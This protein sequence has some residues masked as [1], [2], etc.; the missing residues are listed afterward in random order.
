MTAGNFINKKNLIGK[1]LILFLSLIVSVGAIFIIGYNVDSYFNAKKALR[2]QAEARLAR[3]R[4]AQEEALR[5]EQK[6]REQAK[7]EVRRVALLKDLT[8]KAQRFAGE[9]KLQEAID[10]LRNYKGELMEETEYVRN[11]LAQEL[12]QQLQKE[13]AAKRHEIM[14][15]IANLLLARKYSEAHKHTQKHITILPE[16]I[17]SVTRDLTTANQR[18]AG[19]FEKDVGGLLMVNLQTSGLISAKL[20]RI[21]G[22]NLIIQQGNQEKQIAV[23]EIAI[24]ER[25]KR[26]KVLWQETQ[27]YYLAIEHWNNKNNAM[28]LIYASQIKSEFGEHIRLLTGTATAQIA[29]RNAQVELYKILRE[30]QLVVNDFELRQITDFLNKR[31]AT[32]VQNRQF[33]KKL[34]DYQSKFSE[35]GFYKSQ[36]NL[37]TILQSYIDRN[38]DYLA[39]AGLNSSINVPLHQL[40]LSEYPP[41]AFWDIPPADVKYQYSKLEFDKLNSVNMIFVLG[42]NANLRMAFDDD[43]DFMNKKAISLKK[44]YQINFNIKYRNG[45]H[46]SSE[47]YSI[48]LYFKDGKVFYKTSSI[49]SGEVQI[50]NQLYWVELVD[51]KSTGKYSDNDDVNIFIYNNDKGKKLL[52]HITAKDQFSLNGTKYQ[53]A[54]INSQGTHVK[55]TQNE[56]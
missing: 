18:I 23:H 16:N 22:D 38:V 42:A 35:T 17:L 25:E 10:L 49:R 6:R 54:K 4:A 51:Y 24:E 46:E 26:I 43:T 34:Q 48:T 11:S 32:S 40:Q 41:E 20:L 5:L 7:Q 31:V 3:E 2:D 47:P 19:T 14:A 53:I 15:E 12:Y 55:F 52:S 56:P 45:D 13:L 39:Y 8:E 21:D 37:I 50:G 36:K 27:N 30:E 44:P 1:S 29:E 9:K 28:V 33:K